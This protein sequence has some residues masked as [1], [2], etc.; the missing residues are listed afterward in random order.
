M[1]IKSNI[2]VCVCKIKINLGEEKFENILKCERVKREDV[3]RIK[4]ERR[5]D[6]RIERNRSRRGWWGSR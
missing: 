3:K 6:W 1:N 5:E 2:I 4:G